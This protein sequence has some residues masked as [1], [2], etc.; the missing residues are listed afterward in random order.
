MNSI[1]KYILFSFTV[2]IFGF[3]NEFVNSKTE[4]K[5]NLLEA[6]AKTHKELEFVKC[7]EVKN[8]QIIYRATYRVRGNKSKIVEGFL[9]ENYGMGNLKWA[10]C[11]WDNAGVYGQFE[12]PEFEKIDPYCSA[13]ISMFASGE[14]IDKSKNTINLEHDRDK[15]EYFTV[16]VEL[17]IT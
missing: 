8:S 4:L 10:C 12:H 5:C 1:L 2:L 13:V 9:K 3:S 17:I 7:E 15:I 14:K 16:T 6:Y 11:G